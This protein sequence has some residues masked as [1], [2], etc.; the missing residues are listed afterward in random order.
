MAD[1]HLPEDDSQEFKLRALLA[2]MRG[3]ETLEQKQLLLRELADPHSVIHDWLHGFENWAEQ[4]FGG[5]SSRTKHADETLDRIATTKLHRDVTEYVWRQRAHGVISESDASAIIA[6]G[7][8]PQAEQPSSH[9]LKTSAQCMILALSARYPQF[10]RDLES[11][12]MG[13]LP[14]TTLGR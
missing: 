7:A 8:V 4:R 12:W 1:S 3:R 9:A 13:P 11:L 5:P 2:A 10:R 6:A 14:G